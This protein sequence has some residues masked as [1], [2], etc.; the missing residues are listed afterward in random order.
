MDLK[1]TAEDIRT[2][3]IVDLYPRTGYVLIC[4]STSF[5]RKTY[6]T[7]FISFFFFLRTAFLFEQVGDVGPK[8]IF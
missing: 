5:V 6:V 1:Q 8:E 7:L 3:L 2:I 4:L